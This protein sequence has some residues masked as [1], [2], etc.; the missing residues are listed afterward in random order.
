M[1]TLTHWKKLRDPNY[2][3]SWDIE[4]GK[5][6]VVT[7]ESV[8][9]EL[10][11]GPEGKKE[12]CTVAKLK[13][14]KPMIL[15]ATNAKTIAKVCGSPFIEQ[16]QNKRITLYVAQIKAFGELVDALRIRATAPELPTLNES[17]P[18][19]ASAKQSLKDGKVTID[20]IKANYKLSKEDEK[21]IQN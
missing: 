15:N 1:T 14:M 21:A 7:L 6:L 5:E 10:V 12:Y 2:I 13:G 16:W 9:K 3:G 17:H 20:Q 8:S 19:W 4:Q 18:K 11:T